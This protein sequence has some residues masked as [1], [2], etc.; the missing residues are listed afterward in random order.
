MCV[1]VH[2]WVC[3]NLCTAATEHTFISM[4]GRYM[5]PFPHNEATTIVLSFNLQENA[6]IPMFKKAALVYL[7]HCL[8]QTYAAQTNTWKA[9]RNSFRLPPL[10]CS[11]QI[12]PDQHDTANNT[13]TRNRQLSKVCS[14]HPE[15]HLPSPACAAVFKLTILKLLKRA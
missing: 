10:T 15:P 7:P 4:G 3:M 12:A 13:M 1:H 14:P 9:V 6:R 11:C 2:A 8:P 5:L